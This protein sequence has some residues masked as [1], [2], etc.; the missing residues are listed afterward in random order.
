VVAWV[1]IGVY[2][3]LPWIPLKGSPAI[4]LDVAN[5]RFH[6]FGLT[7]A[8]QD[9]WLLFFAISG[10]GCLLFLITSLLGRIWCGWT[11]PQTV[12]LD[13][14]FEGLSAGSMV[15][16]RPGATWIVRPCPWGKRFAGWQSILSTCLVRF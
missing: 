4:F 9:L 13:A 16:P 8:A 2:A 1:L 5:R 11:C 10:L 12:F 15:M 3:A 14:V 7:L 6:L